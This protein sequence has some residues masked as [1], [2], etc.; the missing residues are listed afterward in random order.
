M[1]IDLRTSAATPNIAGWPSD[2]ANLLSS[3]FAAK[4]FFT[5]EVSGVRLAL[6]KGKSIHE[7]LVPINLLQL[8]ISTGLADLSLQ[9][10]LI[11]GSANELKEA[12]R[13][14]LAQALKAVQSKTSTMKTAALRRLLLRAVAL[15]ISPPGV[16][17]QG[18]SPHG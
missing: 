7:P 11:G 9:A 16:S 1:T 13:H 3:Q 6:G 17:E 10:P 18:S 8:A 5:G 4:Q 12:F 14:Q 15:V 2:S